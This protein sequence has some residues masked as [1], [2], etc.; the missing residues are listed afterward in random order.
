[1]AAIDALL[2]DMLAQSGSDLHLM[3]GEPPRIRVHGELVPTDRPV[4]RHDDLA[5]MMAEICAQDRW[6]HFQ[7]HHDLD[8]AYEIPGTARFRVNYLM[9]YRGLAGVLRQ[10]PS[11]ILSMEELQLPTVLERFCEYR[12]GLVLVTGPTGSGKSTTMAA[13]IDRINRNDN[14]HIITLED[15]IEFVHENMKSVIV[16]REIGE[17]SQSFRASLSSATRGDPDIVFV[18]EMREL[19]TI[20]LAL[21]CAAMGMLVFGTL[22]TNN[23][24]KTID[25]IIDVFPADAQP[26]IR[27]LLAEC[28]AGVVSQLL[29]RRQDGEG[30]V[31]VHEILFYTDAL[32][33]IIRE[34]QTSSIRTLIESNRSAGMCTMDSSLRR[35]LRKKMISAEEAYMKASSK[36]DFAAAAPADRKPKA[37]AAASK[38][39]PS[40]DHAAE[41][42]LPK[43][44]VPLRR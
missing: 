10:I 32:P 18:G 13:L 6:Q 34:G 40:T 22:H 30:R 29:C 24:P 44:K 14:K 19:E 20:R 35:L 28:L 21:S 12:R 5:A 7:T 15:P 43:R 23:A 25:R 38:A 8:F 27:T 9:D 1:M 4:L 41:R 3:V 26:Q 42:P 39:P 16:H 33:N 37:A 31:A 11:R 2:T 17:H 36:D